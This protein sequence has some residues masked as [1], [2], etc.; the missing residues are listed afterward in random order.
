MV[1]LLEQHPPT[2]LALRAL[3][4]CLR[5]MVR[6]NPH[7]TLRIIWHIFLRGIWHFGAHFN[8]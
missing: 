2:A 7:V 6:S 3:Q 1:A 4:S 8:P 5:D